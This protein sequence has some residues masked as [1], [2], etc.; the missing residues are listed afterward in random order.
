L[1]GGPS[2]AVRL[3]LVDDSA[4]S[5]AHLSA[6]LA[7][8]PGVEIVGQASDGEQGL[9]EVDRLAPDVIVLD[10]QMPRMDGFTFLRLLMARRPTPVLVVSSQSHQSD[11]FRAMELGALDFVAKPDGRRG[12]LDAFRAELLRKCAAVRAVRVEKLAARPPGLAAAP[13]GAP[14]VVT[15]GASTG[16]PQAVQQLLAAIP[17]RTSLAVLLAQHMPEK[18]TASF[19]E[20]LARTAAFSAKEAAE[21]DLVAAGR[22]LVAP[23]GHHLQVVR[24]AEGSLRARVHRG[25]V[26][27]ARYVPSVDRLFTSA[28]AACGRHLCGVVLT[29][30]GNDGQAGIQAIR[31]GG[32]LT[33]AESADTAV[34]YGMPQA[35]VET[36]AVDEVLALGEIAG[37]LI[38]FS[39]EC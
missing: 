20:R 11:V 16:G 13:A 9:R 5:R 36:G 2:P 3:L 18:F 27:T 24:D 14:R 39:E 19:A 10:L 37:R 15:I 22:V 29:G 25:S 34:V 12:S 4:I 33:I 26:A 23:G 1:S 31:R 30:M 8:A 17:G 28:A 21:G 6:V 38:R 7:G 35:A 32:G